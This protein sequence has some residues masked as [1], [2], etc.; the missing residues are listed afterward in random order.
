M[1]RLLGDKAPF[2]L[3]GVPKG[4]DDLLNPLGNQGS[5]PNTDSPRLEIEFEKGRA[6]KFSI[7]KT[8]G[9]IRNN[10]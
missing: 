4:F 3:W 9:N 2:Y 1:F 7:Y 5:N 8:T 6:Y 10:Q